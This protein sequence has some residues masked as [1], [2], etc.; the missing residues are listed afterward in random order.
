MK[1][2]YTIGMTFMVGGLLL[3]G[4][5][6]CAKGDK[7][8]THKD[9]LSTAPKTTVTNPYTYDATCSVCGK[10]TKCMK[11]GKKKDGTDV[12]VC[13]SVCAQS[14]VMN[15]ANAPLQQQ[16]GSVPASDYHPTNK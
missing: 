1:K 5:V 16:G 12:F 9:L 6:G 15:R 4:I 8:D 11:Y 2:A 3:S 10:K 14:Y 7:V 13:S